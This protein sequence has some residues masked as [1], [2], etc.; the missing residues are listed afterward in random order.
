MK[1]PAHGH[2]ATLM[3]AW[4]GLAVG[5]RIPRG[6]NKVHGAITHRP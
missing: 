6:D 2:A 5:A 1:L 4:T 3:F